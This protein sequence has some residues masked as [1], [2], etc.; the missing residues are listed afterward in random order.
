MKHTESFVGVPATL[1][2]LLHKDYESQYLETY[3]SIRSLVSLSPLKNN[4]CFCY[5]GIETIALKYRLTE[6]EVHESV[7]WL[8]EHGYLYRLP[9]ARRPITYTIVLE[10]ERF[11]RI[12]EESGPD[13]A[14]ESNEAWMA[15]QRQEALRK[16]K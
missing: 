12:R 9:R 8:E 7:A 5:P 6:D 4:F 10:R 11:L 2:A 1:N 15:K 14:I 13:G 16:N 3:I